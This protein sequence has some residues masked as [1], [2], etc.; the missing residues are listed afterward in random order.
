MNQVTL[1]PPQSSLTT[2]IL[3]SLHNH[4]GN[5]PNQ[6]DSDWSFSRSSDVLPVMIILSTAFSCSRSHSEREEQTSEAS[7]STCFHTTFSQSLHFPMPPHPWSVVLGILED[8]TT[9]RKAGKWDLIQAQNLCYR[10]WKLRTAILRLN[11]HQTTPA[12]CKQE[13][14]QTHKGIMEQF[15]PHLTCKGSGPPAH[16]WKQVW[17][18]HVHHQA[19][20]R[21]TFTY[22]NK[23]VISNNNN[24]STI[25]I[26]FV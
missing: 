23:S 11:S 10:E 20:R 15:Y 5:S 7:P 12:Q 22:M 3:K 9:F 8:E 18:Q 19:L 1:H 2:L 21:I 26:K 16:R 14:H 24:H 17:S 6:S 25:T 4:P 13:S